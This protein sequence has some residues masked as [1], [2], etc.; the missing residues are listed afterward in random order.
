MSA[1]RADFCPC[2][3]SLKSLCL[4]HVFP[5]QNSAPEHEIAQKRCR[6]MYK[7]RRGPRSCSIF[8]GL[9]MQ[10]FSFIEVKL[11]S[12]TEKHIYLRVETLVSGPSGILFLRSTSFICR[13]EKCFLKC[14]PICGAV[15][16]S[17]LSETQCYKLQLFS[18][19]QHM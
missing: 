9:Q 16:F 3:R 14:Y 19:S 1:D 6:H 11:I 5:A 13:N 8:P 12:A 7:Y 15:S 2:A 4:S 17:Y 18:T 10:E